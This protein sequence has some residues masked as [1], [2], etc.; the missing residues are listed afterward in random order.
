MSADSKSKNPEVALNAEVDSDDEE[1]DELLLNNQDYVDEVNQRH[2]EF[3][4]S[5]GAT[6][7]PKYVMV[8]CVDARIQ[9]ATLLKLNPGELFIH[10]NIAN[11]FNQGDMN[12]NAVLQYAIEGLNI[13]RIIVLGHSRCGGIMASMKEI[14]FTVVDQW[15][16]NIRDMY[17]THLKFFEGIPDEIDR[18]AALA[19]V[20]VRLQCIN[21][22]KSAV[23]QKALQEGKDIHI[24]GLY[25]DVT[26]GEIENLHFNNKY[27]E[28]VSEMYSEALVGVL[29]FVEAQPLTGLVEGQTQSTLLRQQ[30]L[31]CGSSLSCH[32]PKVKDPVTGLFV[33]DHNHEH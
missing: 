27:I 21:I 8:G 13:N 14:P 26:S 17:D 5:L 23:V 18:A 12:A 25:Y 10:R 19:K 33:D 32:I 7:K 3:F 2:P 24:Y 9:P 28:G 20:N 16:S 22:R 29:K 30:S 6:H 4:K 15:I 31:R 1:I 11:Q